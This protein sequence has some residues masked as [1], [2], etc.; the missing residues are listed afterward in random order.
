MQSGSTR[1]LKAM[2]RGYTKEDYLDLAARI[3]EALPDLAL[4]TDIIVGF[5]G[6][7]AEDV[8]ET[9]EVVE[10]VKFANA[11]TFLY[12]E[13]AGTAAAALPDRVPPEEAKANFDRLV[14]AVQETAFAQT[15]RLVGETQPVLVEEVNAKNP[16][17]LDGR[18]SNNTLV[19]FPGGKE[20]I[21]KIV[22]VKLEEA[23][24]YYYM[25]VKE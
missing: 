20:L 2:N 4:T 3:R 9:I 24:G 12:S 14:A 1:I 15:A 13:R 18:L 7:T 8:N 17:L 22:D 23:R 5:P 10:Q 25:G 21:G 11:F 6:E 16:A 19:H